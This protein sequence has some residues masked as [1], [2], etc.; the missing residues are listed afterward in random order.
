MALRQLQSD[1]LSAALLTFTS[2]EEE[3][4]GEGWP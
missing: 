1:L 3:E 4:G 2:S